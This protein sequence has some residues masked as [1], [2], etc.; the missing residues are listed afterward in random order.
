MEKIMKRYLLLGGL[1]VVAIYQCGSEETPP[2][3]SPPA[4]RQAAEAEAVQT[5]EMADGLQATGA[6][7]CAFAYSEANFKGQ[8]I[9]LAATVAFRALAKGWGQLIS[10]VHV[11]PGCALETIGGFGGTMSALDCG[12][13]PWL[14]LADNVD[15]YQCSC[16]SGAQAKC[17][18]AKA[19]TQDSSSPDL[20]A[21]PAY[22]SQA[23]PETEL[24][25]QSR[26]QFEAQRR[27]HAQGLAI[28]QNQCTPNTCHRTKD[29]KP[30]PSSLV[31]P[32]ATEVF[33]QNFDACQSHSDARGWCDENQNCISLGGA[34]VDAVPQLE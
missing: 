24:A 13:N 32:R 17:G 19:K 27:A 11:Q 28:V 26:E 10:S 9:S 22:R 14:N 31:L 12:D 3:S 7:A 15:Q 25:K 5:A 29:C 6:G 33:I 16:G 18:G 30:E 8:M 21:K 34:F 1:I 23:A 2:P 20:N 4:E